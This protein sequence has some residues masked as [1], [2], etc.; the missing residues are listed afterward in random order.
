VQDVRFNLNIL[1]SYISGE[2]FRKDEKGG[3]GEQ[4]DVKTRF[5]SA[6]VQGKQF[7]INT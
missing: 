7:T 6:P 2:P 3:A 4:K 5:L 1:F